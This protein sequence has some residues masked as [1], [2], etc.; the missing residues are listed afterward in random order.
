M[1]E[2]L[3]A[4]F[5]QLGQQIGE[6]VQIGPKA[7]LEVAKLRQEQA[8]KK[9]K[10]SPNEVLQ[11]LAMKAYYAKDKEE[12]A[13]YMAEFV[14]AA[15]ILGPPMERIKRINA[16]YQKTYGEDLPMD[17]PKI[18]QAPLPADFF[19]DPPK[20]PNATLPDNIMESFS[21]GSIAAMRN[22]KDPTKQAAIDTRYSEKETQLRKHFHE[23]DPEAGPVEV[24]D[25]VSQGMAALKKRDKLVWEDPEEAKKFKAPDKV[26]YVQTYGYERFGKTMRKV[27]KPTGGEGGEKKPRAKMSAQDTQA[28]DWA[29][30]NAKD[31]KAK[32]IVQKLKDE[33]KI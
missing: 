16:D 1:A 19:D 12:R 11:G 17:E 10:I 25:F 6:L 28:Y 18:A 33:G 31:P 4:Q 29:K 13:R 24:N 21:I 32:K 8:E 26:D 14:E 9:A 7:D 3:G 2:D 23:R 27:R 22:A 15:D 30:K 20:S 5:S